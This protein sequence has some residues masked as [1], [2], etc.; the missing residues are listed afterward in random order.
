MDV[1]NEEVNCKHPVGLGVLENIEEGVAQGLEIVAAIEFVGRHIGLFVRLLEGE[2]VA[3][4]VHDALL[5]LPLCHC[6]YALPHSPQLSYLS[7]VKIV[8]QL[9]PQSPRD[10]Q[11][12]AEWSG[13]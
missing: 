5:S 8:L 6:P 2:E 13:G 3:K 11:E 1:A 4:H 12:L 7:Q 9:S 10:C